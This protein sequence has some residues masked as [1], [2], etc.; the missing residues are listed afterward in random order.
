MYSKSDLSFWEL[1]ASNE[2]RSNST[3][4][5]TNGRLSI[6]IV[7]VVALSILIMINFLFIGSD[8]LY[9]NNQSLANDTAST[10]LLCHYLAQTQQRHYL[11]I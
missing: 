9:F 11:L 10:S 3:I 6:Y 8:K 4:T 7:Y 2:N 5:Y 1:P